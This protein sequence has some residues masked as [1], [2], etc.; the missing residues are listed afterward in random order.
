[1]F[2]W[3]RGEEGSGLADAFV[4]VAQSADYGDP[5]GAGVCGEEE[6]SSGAPLR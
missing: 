5:S 4:G 2:G 1:L 3:E 6:V